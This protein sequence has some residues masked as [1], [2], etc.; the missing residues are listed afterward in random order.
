[1]NA[2]TDLCAKDVVDKPVLC[3]AAQARERGRA[4]NRLEVVPVTADDGS[5]ARDTRLDPL[6]Q[7][8]RSR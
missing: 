4:H 3:D 6:L 5:S 7:L 2:V 1:M 8:L